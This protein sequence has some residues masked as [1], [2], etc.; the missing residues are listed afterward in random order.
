MAI[1]FYN[2]VDQESYTG[3]EH[4]I[5]RQDYRLNYTPSTALASTVGGTGGVTGTQAAYPYIWPPQGGG[6]GG[7]P[8]G[9]NAITK[10]LNVRSWQELEGPL[11][12]RQGNKGWVNK[13]ITGYKTPSGWKTAKDKNIFHA[14]MFKNDLNRNIGDIEETEMDFSKF[15]SI[16]GLI[17]TKLRNW[18]K[19]REIKKQE[20]IAADKV[21]AS[22]EAVKASGADVGHY[23]PQAGGAS[24]L[25]R[26]RNVGGLGLTQ[27]QA[28]SVSDANKDAGYSSFSGLAQGG[29][30]GYATQG[31]VDPEEPAENIFEVMQDQNIPFSEQVEG[32]EGILQQL[33]AKYI[34]AGF[35]PD[36]AEAMAMQ[37]FQQMSAGP[38]QDQGIASLV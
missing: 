23:D 35:P 7:D 11:D 15:P 17:T 12:A 29:R 9:P 37:E 38:E 3:G 26:G 10:D 22:K 25:T 4:F 30:I 1:P 32:E 13:T 14:G 21:A 2:Q 16:T 28:Q 33:V 18:K 5:P 20:K 19:N 36:Q 24:H 34:E 6:G 27:A 31:F 8:F